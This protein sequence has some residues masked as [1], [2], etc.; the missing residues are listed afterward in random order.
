[1]RLGRTCQSN[2]AKRV[3]ESGRD[4]G[5]HWGGQRWDPAVGDAEAVV[6]RGGSAMFP[7]S[8]DLMED[9][10]AGACLVRERAPVFFLT[11]PAVLTIA[12]CLSVLNHV[13]PGDNPATAWARLSTAQL[14][15]H[16][17]ASVQFNSVQS[18]SRVQIFATP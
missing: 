8:L 10:A 18:L 17:P 9:A 12:F 7:L 16:A 6:T 11:M 15:V 3:G 13:Q 1:M 5:D 2:C 14:A 4:G